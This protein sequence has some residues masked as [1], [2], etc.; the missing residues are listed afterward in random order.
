MIS[1]IILTK[2]KRIRIC[3]NEEYLKSILKDLRDPIVIS[4]RIQVRTTLNPVA[5]WKLWANQH[6]NIKLLPYLIF[7]FF[8]LIK[9][10]RSW[11]YYNIHRVLHRTLMKGWKQYL[12]L[13][14]RTIRPR[15]TVYRCRSFVY[16]SYSAVKDFQLT[17]NIMQP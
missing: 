10:E 3:Q 14:K 17:K 8:D 16:K 15:V 4:F 11:K 6:N 13:Y 5:L 7:R 12:V 9:W 1:M 2:H